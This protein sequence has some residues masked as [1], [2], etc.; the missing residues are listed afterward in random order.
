MAWLGSYDIQ[1]PIIPP[2]NADANYT[3]TLQQLCEIYTNQYGKNFNTVVIPAIGVIFDFDY[4]FWSD[5]A[6]LKK[7]FETNFLRHFYMREIAYETP[8]YWKLKLQDAF[9]T[10]MPY[11]SK[12]MQAAL[13]AADLDWTLTDDYYIDFQ[14]I[15]NEHRIIKDDNTTSDSGTVNRTTN[16]T[17]TG[18]NTGD[19]TSNTTTNSTSNQQHGGSDVTSESGSTQHNYDKAITRTDTPQDRFQQGGRG[20][21]YATDVL[22]VMMDYA[23]EV[24]RENY[25]GSDTAVDKA[26]TTQY[27]HTINNT[28]NGSTDGAFNTNSTSNTTL[29]TDD[30]TKKSNTIDFKGNK[31]DDSNDDIHEVTHESGRRGVAWI[32]IYDKYMKAIRN[33]EADIY[34]RFDK[35]LFLQ[36]WG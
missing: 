16:Q 27:G 6:E 14:H 29:N 33:I 32:D 10:W 30:N 2:F 20:D 21:E 28:D 8:T 7:V 11:Y 18:R 17:G 31:N 3:I 36:I 13:R 5:N 1:H 12:L 19:G 22:D 34:E 26:S 15:G 4:V 35:L 25:R 9:I 23:S 24:T